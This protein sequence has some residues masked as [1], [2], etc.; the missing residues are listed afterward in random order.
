MSAVKTLSIIGMVFFGLCLLL[1][2][3]FAE[4]DPEAAAG[5]GLFAIL[6]GIGYSITTFVKVKNA[7]E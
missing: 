2:G 3:A 6:Y 7:P 5:W 4:S 1:V